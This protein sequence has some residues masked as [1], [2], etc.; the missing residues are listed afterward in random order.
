MFESVFKENVLVASLAFQHTPWTIRRNNGT[1][2]CASMNFL[3]N[4]CD[5]LIRVKP[6]RMVLSHAHIN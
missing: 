3:T 4:A 6:V 5:G 2:I 1:G